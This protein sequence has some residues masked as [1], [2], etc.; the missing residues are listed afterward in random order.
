MFKSKYKIMHMSL[1][2]EHILSARNKSISYHIIRQPWNAGPWKHNKNIVR[3]YCLHSGII[4]LS[5]DFLVFIP[6]P[7]IKVKEQASRMLHII[8][9][10]LYNLWMHYKYA[11]K[12]YFKPSDK[13][14]VWIYQNDCIS[15]VGKWI[16]QRKLCNKD[17]PGQE[18]KQVYVTGS[19]ASLNP[20]RPTNY[21]RASTLFRVIIM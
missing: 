18:S 7:F 20:N 1:H 9:Y 16:F 5:L 11:L 13:R 19:N 3:F 6:Y 14:L 17:L 8:G 4:K 21:T 10:K 15:M 2:T 12:H